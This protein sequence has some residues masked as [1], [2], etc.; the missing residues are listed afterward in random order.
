MTQNDTHAFSVSPCCGRTL[1]DATAIED[2]TLQPQPGDYSVCAYC[3]AW[4]RFGDGG[5][6]RRLTGA[7]V[8]SLDK[9]IRA[10]MEKVQRIVVKIKS[11]REKAKQ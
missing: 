8:R 10:Y 1:N 7:E 9:D 5:L 11:E 2:P 4:L 6:C 3:S